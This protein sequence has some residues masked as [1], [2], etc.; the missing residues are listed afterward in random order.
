MPGL[1]PLE[2]APAPVAPAPR[3]PPVLDHEWSAAPLWRRALAAGLDALVPCAVWALAT[4]ALVASDPE[5]ALPPWNLFDQIVDY[6]HDRSAR[7]A[8]SIAVLV[9]AQVA[10]PIVFAGRTPGKRAL[11]LALIGVDGRAPTV[12]RVAAWALW[13]VPSI[14]LGG[15]G[16]WWALVDVERRTLHDR[17]AGLW[18][19]RVAPSG[20]SPEP[21]APPRPSAARIR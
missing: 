12:G 15:L 6:L 10:W 13:R 7:S 17:L 4:W 2:P 16:A 18:L 14:A 8:L 9:L 1:P 5:L 11:G 21:V 20:G 19:V 3:P